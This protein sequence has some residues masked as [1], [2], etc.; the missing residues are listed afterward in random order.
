[1]YKSINPNTWP[2]GKRAIQDTIKRFFNESNLTVEKIPAECI[3]DWYNIADD[4]NP[5]DRQSLLSLYGKEFV[6]WL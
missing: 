1:M 6:G 2:R 4:I 3:P 5:K